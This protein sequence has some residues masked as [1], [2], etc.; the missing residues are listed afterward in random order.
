MSNEET[1]QLIQEVLAAQEEII[2]K[3]SALPTEKL[4]ARVPIGQRQS[5]LRNILYQMVLHPREHSSE[6]KKILAETDGPR[7]TE[8]QNIMAQAR[9]SM[10]NLMG[11]F[12]ALDDSDLDRQFEGE[13]RSIRA[14]LLHLK[15]AHQL[16]LTG[17][18]NVLE[19]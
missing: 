7:A 11:N 19:S 5:A 4:D 6:I 14:I 13:D 17:I 15:R 9:E 3:A 8:V 2:Q 16:Y 12:T 18:D 1:T 10:A